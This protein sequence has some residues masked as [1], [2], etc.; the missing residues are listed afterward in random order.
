MVLF[1]EEADEHLN[2]FA[3][4]VVVPHCGL[5]LGLGLVEHEAIEHQSLALETKV[6]EGL[7][8]FQ[9]LVGWIHLFSKVLY[10]RKILTQLIK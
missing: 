10:S 5:V 8:K 3:L 6:G 7:R 2:G 9:F 1:L 4:D